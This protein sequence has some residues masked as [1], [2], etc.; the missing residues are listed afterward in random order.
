MQSGRVG[1][2]ELHHLEPFV[3]DIH[4]SHDGVVFLGVQGRNDTVPILRHDFAFDLD[5][6]AEFGREIDL[7]ALKLAAGAREIPGRIGALGGDLDDLVLR[8]GAA[9]YEGGGQQSETN[10][11]EE[12]HHRSLWSVFYRAIFRRRF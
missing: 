2:S 4:A 6:R 10:C 8:G 12:F 9:D 1:T 5:P 3:G 11:F 7:E